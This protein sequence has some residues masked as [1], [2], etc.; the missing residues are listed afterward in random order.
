MQ[1]SESYFYPLLIMFFGFFLMLVS[2]AF[3][4]PIFDI[5]VLVGLVICVLTAG[6]V[7]VRH[8]WY[9]FFQL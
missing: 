6:Y 7:V 1:L 9:V 3:V 5:I 2:G 8:L 4:F